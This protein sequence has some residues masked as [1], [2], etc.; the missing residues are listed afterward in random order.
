MNPK[1]IKRPSQKQI[2]DAW[3]NAMV[4]LIKIRDGVTEAQQNGFK[5]T[6]QL[7]EETGMSKT[8][9][10]RRLSLM[11]WEELHVRHNGRKVTMYRPKI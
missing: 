3:S 8:T 2:D 1:E 10:T 7:S 4:E 11:G 5:T 6:K 9:L